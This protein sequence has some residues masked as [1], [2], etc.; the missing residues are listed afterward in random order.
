MWEPDKSRVVKIRLHNLGEDVETLWAEDLG[1]VPTDPSAR[2]VRLGN[3][4]F[5]HAKPTYGDVIEVRP[6][7]DGMLEWDRQDAA[8]EDIAI[9]EDDGRWTMIIDYRTGPG[10][11][12]IKAAF[13]AL[14]QAADRAGIVVEGVC[15]EGNEGRACL[16]VPSDLSVDDAL[17]WLRSP[18]VNV[19]FTLVHPVDDDDADDD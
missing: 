9:Y 8:Y 17:T 16:A 4:P 3:V 14:G 5:L 1:E 19:D 7:D 2:H 13:R 15:A 11:A 6:G 10:D 18:G 12:D